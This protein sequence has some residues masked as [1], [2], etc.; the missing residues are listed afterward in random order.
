MLPHLKTRAE[1]KEEVEWGVNARGKAAKT[2]FSLWYQSPY[3]D[4]GPLTFG[5]W[6]GVRNTVPKTQSSSSSE[7]GI[8]YLHTATQAQTPESLL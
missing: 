2:C 7:T 6:I 5:R 4:P 3:P 1:R 8:W